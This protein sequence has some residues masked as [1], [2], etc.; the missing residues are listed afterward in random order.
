M[1]AYATIGVIAVAML[2]RSTRLGMKSLFM[3]LAET[4]R[5]TTPAVGACAAAGLV[6]GGISMTG[7]GAKFTDL[8]FLLAGQNLFWSLVIAAVV[9]ILLGMGMPVP[10]VYILAA[11]LIAPALTKLGVPL[12]AAHLF[13]LYFASLSAMTP[14]VAVAAFAAAPIA[15][16]NPLLIGVAAVKLAVAA[17][18]MPFAFAY[19][20]EILLQGEVLPIILHIVAAMIAVVLLSVAVEGFLRARVNGLWRAFIGA[21]GLALLANDWRVQVAAAV[22]GLALFAYLA[23][24]PLDAVNADTDYR[25]SQ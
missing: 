8:I 4:A 16:G 9:V 11:V 6:V 14:P 25:N 13:L 2:R 20:G 1:A 18:V 5:R 17:F 15:E 7:L 21:C 10:S 24:G 3:I 22:L 12:L 19:S 23:R